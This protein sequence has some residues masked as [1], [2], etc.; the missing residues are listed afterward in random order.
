[1]LIPVDG[2]EDSICVLH[3]H[4]FCFLPT[5]TTCCFLLYKHSRRTTP[6][7]TWVTCE[8]LDVKDYGGGYCWQVSPYGERPPE[9]IS[10]IGRGEWEA[11]AADDRTSVPI[12]F[13]TEDWSEGAL[14]RFEPSASSL[15]AG[16]QTLHGGG[17]L[18]FLVF[19]NVSYDNRGNMMG[20]FSWTS[21]IKDGRKS[22]K[23]YFPN[24][25]GIVF[26]HIDNKPLLFFVSKGRRRLYK[27]NLDTYTFTST[28]TQNELSDGGSFWN[29]PDAL[30]PV[31]QH[32]I[33]Q[34]EEGGGTPGVYFKD[35]RSGQYRTIFQDEVEPDKDGDYG[36]ETT[37]L[38]ISPSG[39]CLL[40]CLQDRG[41]CFVFERE[42]GGNFEELAPK[43]RIR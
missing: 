2:L 39:K 42:D 31:G 9:R 23:Q 6:W 24:L 1:M 11:M 3:L 37:G 16:W 20:R 18:T 36:E 41:E 30:L 34:T 21:N 25:E 29:S 26:M 17:D 7:N 43:L 13:F 4:L 5:S 10:A 22:Q 28:S 38:A 19:E 35:L 33:Y 12:F 27:L 8:E 32:F 40:S 15:P 14:R